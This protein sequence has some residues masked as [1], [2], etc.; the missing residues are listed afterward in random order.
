MA[1]EHERDS[2]AIVD[3]HL[4]ITLGLVC[5]DI[6]EHQNELA[7]RHLALRHRHKDVALPAEIGKAEAGEKADIGERHGR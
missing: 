1:V 5:A 7:R 2:A 4:E 6:I 3:Q